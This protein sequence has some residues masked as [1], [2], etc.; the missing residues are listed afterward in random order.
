MGHIVSGP[1]QNDRKKK[2][3]GR[4]TQHEVTALMEQVRLP[5]RNRNSS[6]QD[7]EDVH[8]HTGQWRVGG[9]Q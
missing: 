7:D 2:S 3:A 5:H 6:E 9:W 4:G 8:I 1:K